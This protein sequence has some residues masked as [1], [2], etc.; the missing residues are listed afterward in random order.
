MNLCL[1]RAIY[2]IAV[3]TNARRAEYIDSLIY[4]QDRV[5]LDSPWGDASRL[6]ALVAQACQE[7]LIDYLRMLATAGDSRGTDGRFY[8]A[9]LNGFA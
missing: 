4:G 5:N 6:T 9:M 3:I 7:S 2:P 1:L 8:R